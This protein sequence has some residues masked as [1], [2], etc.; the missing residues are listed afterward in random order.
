MTNDE[1]VDYIVREMAAG[2]GESEIKNALQ[3]AGWQDADIAENLTAARQRHAVTPLIHEKEPSQKRAFLK[4]HT[5]AIVALVFALLI[6]AGGAFAAYKFIPLSPEKMLQLAVAHMEDVKSLDFSGRITADVTTPD[7]ILNFQAFLPKEIFD[8]ILDNRVA[9]AANNLEFAVDFKGTLDGNDEQHPKGEAELDLSSGIIS[10]GLKMRFID[11]ILYFNLD[12]IPPISE[13]VNKYRNT[14]IKVDP[15][16]ISKQYGLGMNLEGNQTNL[17]PGQRQQIEYLTRQAHFYNSVTRLPN[18]SI[19]GVATYRYSV[20]LDNVGLK[21]YLQQVENI[22][23]AAGGSS[24]SSLEA[25]D[26]MQFKDVE[27]WV[28]RSD[29]MLRRISMRIAQA[30]SGDSIPTGSVH[31]LMN[32]SNFNSPSLIEAPAIYRNVEDVIRDV[33]AG[34]TQ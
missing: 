24:D 29:R 11:K 9:G 15:E 4:K 5:K 27:V 30:P 26:T 8:Q 32:F 33:M 7:N 3:A 14:W 31:F 23:K 17:T 2:T 12:Q 16:A 13:S 1:L 28:G 18:D 20:V 25:I 19:D 10:V 34:G 21:N 6:L 22:N